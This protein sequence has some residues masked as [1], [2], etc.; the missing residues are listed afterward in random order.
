MGAFGQT[1]LTGLA[2]R[3]RN[4]DFRY[5]DRLIENDCDSLSPFCRGQNPAIPPVI[6]P[7]LSASISVIAP[8]PSGRHAKRD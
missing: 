3:T 8:Y 2:S 6:F 5:M 1:K 7:K 4:V